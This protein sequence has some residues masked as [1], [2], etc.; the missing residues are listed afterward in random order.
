[1]TICVKLCTASDEI[2]H[3]SVDTRFLNQREKILEHRWKPFV[4]IPGKTMFL[5][6]GNYEWPFEFTLPSNTIETVE[7]IQ[8]LSVTY[9]LKATINR[10][11]LAHDLHAYKHLR[12]IHTPSLDALELTQPVGV[13]D[14]WSNKIEYSIV[15]PQ[16]SVAFGSSI[17][18]KMRFTPLLKGLELRSIRARLIE[19]RESHFPNSIHT[20]GK[21]HRIERVSSKWD[22]QV[23]REDFWQDMIEESGQEGWV[24]RKTLDLPRELCDCIQ[25]LSLENI[26]VRHKISLSVEL[27]NPDGH[28]SEVSDENFQFF[29]I[30][31]Y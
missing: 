26:K 6:S 4:G 15:I 31:K 27:G 20:S 2:H 18:I 13:D 23:T 14:I 22:I 8:E 17:P 10:G 25:D 3:S 16:K 11:K 1:M 7:G 30:F 5:S 12:I 29:A 9:A 24:I 19:I 21:K 28:I